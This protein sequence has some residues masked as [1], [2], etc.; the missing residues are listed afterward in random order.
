ML[1]VGV[2]GSVCLEQAV[3]VLLDERLVEADRLL[4]LVL[5]HVEHVAHV[6]LP[7]VVLVA[8]LDR[9][10]AHADDTETET[11]T[12]NASPIRTQTRKSRSST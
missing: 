1:R 7:R 9:L 11:E 12:A 2:G 5:L 6:Q 8:E 4:V 10:A 3:V